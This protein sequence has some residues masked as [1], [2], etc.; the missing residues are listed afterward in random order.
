MNNDALYYVDTIAQN[1]VSNLFEP[2]LTLRGGW[3]NVKLQLQLSFSKNL[4]HS[5][6]RFEKS[7]VSLGFF[8]TLANRYRKTA[9]EN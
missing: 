2:A 8:Y 4:S 7:N 1:K 6:L 9:P 5:N 3:K